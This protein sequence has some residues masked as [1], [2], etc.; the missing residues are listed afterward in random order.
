MD[1][2]VRNLPDIIKAAASSNLGIVAL[3]LI[4]LAGLSYGFFRKSKEGWRFAALV[5]MFI[6]CMSFG[7]AAFR[8]ALQ[9][10]IPAQNTNLSAIT[11]SWIAAAEATKAAKTI[12]PEDQLPTPLLSARNAFEV[13][14]K[15]ASLSD[16]KTLD[17]EKTS[18]ALSYLN[19]LYRTTENDSSLKPNAMFWADEAIRHFEETQNRRFLT[20]AIL[21][22]A[23]I[24]LEVA[25]LSNNDKQQ[26][27]S[28]AKDG[29]AIMIK[30]YQTANESQRSSV[31]R[32]TSRF[33]YNLARPK[34]F[35]LSDD[36]DNNYILLSYE[37]A[38]A[39][40][41]LA[42]TETKNANQ[43]ARTTIKASKNPPQDTDKEWVKKLREAQQI[44]KAAW[45]LNQPEL[46]G[47]D[48][49]LS[50]L[51][52]LGVSTIETVAR[53]WNSLTRAEKA[54]R[55]VGYVSELEAD[56][57]SPLREAVVLLQNSE[58]RQS[59]GFDLYYDIARAQAV[60]VA[61]IST[62]ST[63]RAKKEFSELK[64]NFLAAKEYAK[65]SQLEAAANDIAKENTFGLLT[66]EYRAELRK[67]LS[68]D[69]N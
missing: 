61:I 58:L 21:D 47:L 1:D 57:L 49:R 52:V 66:N 62:I 16:R 22:K 45:K 25:Q 27:E 18:K 38:R 17:A 9:L 7:Y 65:L 8:S 59:Y 15:Q 30:A 69:A 37:K 67:L 12:A 55:A 20:E 31:L 3:M 41:E 32:I 56:A 10:N 54:L 48:Q 60:K 14:W 24:Y 11:D 53:E 34:S 46:V 40:Y 35:R 6:G 5:L 33:Y 51:N 50:P 26:F 36:W 29:A 4:L 39:A 64:K 44:L 43:L 28:V 63:L 2:L 42:P 13:S 19:R 68:V 23:A